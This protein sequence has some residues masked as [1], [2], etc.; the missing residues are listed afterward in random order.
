MSRGV[1]AP[2]RCPPLTFR[3]EHT[4][5]PGF[6]RYPLPVSKKPSKSASDAKPKR[7]PK[8]PREVEL[9]PDRKAAA[10]P[11]RTPISLS[12]VIGQDRAIAALRTSINSGRIHHA[13]VFH[14]PPGVGKFTTALAF[15]A[16]ILDGSSAK[17]LAGEIEPDPDSAVA[18]LLGAGTHPDLHIVT[19]EL[20]AIS[21]EPQIR[22]SKQR[23]IAKEVLEEFLIEP[24]SRT[25]SSGGQAM[26]SKV[27]IIDEAELID[28]RGQNTLL[29][30][31][32]EPPVG[33]VI[34]LVTANPE[35]LLPTIRSRS[36]PVAF[37]PLGERE[38]KKCLTGAGVDLVSLNAG[39]HAWL[40]SFSDGSP[41][42]ARLALETGL[43]EWYTTLTP[44]LGELDDG[45]FPIDLGPAIAKLIDE[46]AQA[47]VDRPGND[48][49]SKDAAN[50]AAA[51]L[52]FRL[53][54][55]HFRARL[56]AGAGKSAAEHVMVRDLAALDHVREAE[57][58]FDANVQGLFVFD[59]LAASLIR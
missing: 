57:R 46:W 48:N 34:M 36:Q 39:V 49:A 54:A 47:W 43:P 42:I 58:Q 32:E 10:I 53:L 8:A 2:V 17:T 35:K 23:N 11:V 59:N 22:D 41:G 52:M 9:K 7:K 15:A 33:S 14:G 55:D 45:R 20:A 24:A 28:A 13:W 29:K 21:R 27:F 26:A 44:M 25:R 19:K 31:L 16:I 56:R 40:M 3:C 37:A 1:P 12:A 50:K 5:T 18:K 30:T 51:R 38:M 4:P 6:I